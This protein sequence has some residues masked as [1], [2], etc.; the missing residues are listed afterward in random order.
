M[1]EGGEDEE[2]DERDKELQ[3]VFKVTDTRVLTL[4]WGSDMRMWAK[5]GMAG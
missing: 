4:T 2:G 3:F 1:S 5:E